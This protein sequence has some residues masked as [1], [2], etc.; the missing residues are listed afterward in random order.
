MKILALG[1]T[2]LGIFI[3]IVLLNLSSPTVIR[4]YSELSEL[5]D[6]TK[7]QT[8]GKVISERVLYEQTKLLNLDNN[9]EVLCNACPVYI[10]RT[11]TIIGTV[12]TYINRTQVNAL[13]IILQ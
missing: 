5:Q 10:N 7:V 2:L 4:N 11:L 9:I 1:I 13:K 3:L 8:T 12:E 6:Y